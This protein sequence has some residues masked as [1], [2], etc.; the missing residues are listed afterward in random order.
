MPITND[1]RPRSTTST[2]APTSTTSTTAATSTAPT[3]TAPSSSSSELHQTHFAGTVASVVERNAAPIGNAV[4]SAGVDGFAGLNDTAVDGKAKSGSAFGFASLLRP[5][6]GSS[7]P[8]VKSSVAL[9]IQQKGSLNDAASVRQAVDGALQKVAASQG[10]PGAVGQLVQVVNKASA[11]AEKAAHLVDNAAAQ[12]AELKKQVGWDARM[13][14]VI[15]FLWLGIP[16][17]HRAFHDSKKDLKQSAAFSSE[18]GQ[19]VSEGRQQARGEVHKLL[20]AESPAFA[21]L[22]HDHADASLRLNTAQKIVSLADR[23]ESELS[24]ASSYIMLRNMTPQTVNEPVYE[25]RVTNNNGVAS[26]EQVQTGIRLVPNPQHQQYESLALVAKSSAESALRELNGA[27]GVARQL[28]PDKELNAVTGGLIGAFD[29]FG[30][31]SFGLWSYDAS[32]VSTTSSNVSDI[33]AAAGKLAAALQPG[34]D[35]LDAQLNADID[36]R[37]QSLA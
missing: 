37:W 6:R 26:S 30:Q 7:A 16:E 22:A 18:L 36:S 33:S 2:T 14:R 12:T 3:S 13:G 8:P 35:T 1:L 21:A 24:S 19:A 4:A 10:Q 11:Q 32:V 31:A 28:F 25:T 29:Y 23:A 5:F 17:A 34:F 9:L 20:I 15:D 27:V